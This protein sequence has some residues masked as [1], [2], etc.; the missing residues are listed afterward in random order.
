M[1]LSDISVKRPVLAAVAS[2][3]LVAFGII[4]FERLPLRQYPDIDPPVVSVDTTYPGAS[5]S[6]VETRITKLIEDRVSG[7]EGIAFIESSSEDGRSRV[8]IEFKTGRDVNA[9]ANDVRDRVSRILDNLPDEAEPP[10]IEKVDSNEDVIVW[11]NLSG[12]GYSVPELTDYAERYLVDRFSILDGVARVRVGGSQSYAMRVWLDR[13]ALAA[14]G[15][16]T[17]DVEQALRSGNVELPAGTLE[18]RE[19]QFTVRLE[20]AFYDAE[21]FANLVVK[22]GDGGYLVR[23]KDV[24]RVERGTSE[25]RSFFRGNGVPMVGIGIIKQSTANTIEVARQAQ[26]EAKRLNETLPD[27]LEI[28]Q[29]YDTSVFIESAINEVYKTLLIAMGCVILVILLFLGS[30]RAMLV[31]AVTVPV[32]VIATFTVL[33]ALG[34]TINLLTLLALVLAI[35]LVVDDAIVVLENVVRRIKEY[36]ETPLVAAYRGARQVGFAVVATTLVLISVF[37]PVAFVEGDLGRLFTEFAITMAA[38]VAFSSFVALTL[39]PMIASKVLHNGEQAGLAAR[40]V[41]STFGYVRKAYSFT[42]RGALRARF[43]VLALFL[44][45]VG[46]TGWLLT[47]VP[48]EYAPREDRGAFFIIVNGPEGASYSFTKEY[49][50]EIEKRLMPY[51]ES[52]EFQRLLVRAPR[53]FGNAEVFNNGIVIVVLSDWA[54]RRSAWEIMNEVRGKLADLPGVRAFPIMRQGI[55]GALG[56]PVQFTI[57]GGTWDQLAQ[58]RD[59]LLAALEKDNPGLSGI[60]YDYKETQP[61][62][63][64]KID[65]DLAA[66]LGVTVRNIGTTLQTMY[67]SRQVTTYLDDGEEYDVI[68]EGE[69]AL[70]RTPRSLQNVYVRSDTTQKLIPLTNFVKL[71][72]QAGSRSLAR[73]N[74]VR[75]ITIEANLADGLSLGAALDHLEKLARENLPESVI[76]DYKGQSLDYKNAGQSIWF[77]FALGAVIV[78]LVLAAQ[79]ESFIH[80]LVIM[81]TVP[82]AI[83]GGLLGLWLTGGT[84]NIYSQIGLIMLVGLAAKNGILIVEFVNQLRDQGRS[85]DE[86]L[87]EAAQ[88]RLRPILMTG[89]TTAAGSVPLILSF[90][91]GAETRLTIGIVVI[92]GVIA[93]TFLT[94]FVVPVAYSL[95]AR[96]TTSPEAVARQLEQERAAASPAE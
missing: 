60:D 68:L 7:I 44:A 62:I 83:G 90:G 39:S 92:F 22:R 55:G 76:I 52:G 59:T 41:D 94:L 82:L 78:F 48:Q 13:K 6:V 37:V 89:I 15:I 74:R 58:W 3:L 29:S 50:E 79:F 66:E 21:D 16:T 57:G 8:N 2:L 49:M 88:V 25:D 9:A 95:L 27:G 33:F 84:L 77:I 70:Q 10:E 11:L 31:P 19:L 43:L 18:S 67:G 35:G 80:P 26:A 85:F 20:R 42:L 71:E 46:G 1:I 47:Q 75:A 40:I 4:S 14:R 65:Y 30:F 87:Y 54:Q 45:A 34:F 72:E 91:A 23:L 93:A 24:A 38:A 17:A 36:G 73:Y 28:R 32:S 12:A 69:R 86:A 53:S 96:G 81:F 51:T 64:A 63:R 61:Q 56:K 5:A